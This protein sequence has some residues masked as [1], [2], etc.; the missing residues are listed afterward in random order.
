MLMVV[1][2]PALSWADPS[3]VTTTAIPNLASGEGIVF[4]PKPGGTVKMKA[5]HRTIALHDGDRVTFVDDSSA[6]GSEERAE[7]EIEAGGV[8]GHIPNARV[9]T[10]ERIARSPDGTRAVFSA[11]HFCGDVCHGEVWLIEPGRRTRLSDD[12]GPHVVTA[13]S[14]DGSSVAVGAMGL[15]LMSFPD[16]KL[17]KL[18]NYTA[19]AWA[20]DG[21]LVVRGLG[22][23]VRVRGGSDDVFERRGDKFRRLVRSPPDVPLEDG[24]YGMEPMPVTFADDAATFTVTFSRGPGLITWKARRDGK[25]LSK[26]EH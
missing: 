16:G 3:T 12:A 13:W 6:A 9:I 11:I 5:G 25:V 8:K 24:D 1:T 10:E 21:A 4:S 15:Y 20:P 23:E 2:L 17:T 22:G 14:R 26:T 18:S 19:P 7:A